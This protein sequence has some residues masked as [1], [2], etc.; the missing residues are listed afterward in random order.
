M[1]ILDWPK[2]DRPREKLLTKGEAMLTNAELLAIFLNTGSRGKTALDIAKAL[3]KAHGSLQHL[4]KATLTEIREHSGIGPAKYAALRAAMELAKRL[5]N[6]PVKQGAV[7]NNSEVV[8]QFLLTHFREKVH[9]TFACLFLDGQMRLLA[10]EELFQGTIDEAA[11]YPREIVRRAM[12]HNAAKIIL[13]HNHPSGCP[14]PSQAD[15]HIT[16]VLAQTLSV[17][18]MK[19]VDHIIVGGADS[20]SFAESNLI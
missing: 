13:A 20:F 18:D 5:Q 11:V 4:L 12:R 9:E 15:K 8:K 16:R 14:E 2:E 6:E 17:L 1:T 10:F 7:L 19:I 3:L